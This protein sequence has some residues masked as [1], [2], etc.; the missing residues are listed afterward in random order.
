MR[1][2]ALFNFF[3]TNRCIFRQTSSRYSSN[4]ES[5]TQVALLNQTHNPIDGRQR[6]NQAART[7]ILQPE[8]FS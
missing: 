6:V 2:L 5:T 3:F 1:F 8:N 4:R 7:E